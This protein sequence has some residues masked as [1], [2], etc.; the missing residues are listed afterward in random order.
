MRYRVIT[1]SSSMTLEKDVESFLEA[2][3]ELVGGISVCLIG[4]TSFYSQAIAKS[5]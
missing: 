5:I 4:G 1:R 3:W 2:G